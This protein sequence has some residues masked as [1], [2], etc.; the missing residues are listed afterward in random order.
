MKAQAVKTSSGLHGF[1][2]LNLKKAVILTGLFYVVLMKTK[3]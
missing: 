3:A 2:I 1:F